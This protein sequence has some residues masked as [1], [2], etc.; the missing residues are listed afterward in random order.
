MALEQ[1][2]KHAQYALY[3]MMKCTI[4]IDEMNYTNADFGSVQNGNGALYKRQ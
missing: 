4:Q 3:K 1:T 2:C